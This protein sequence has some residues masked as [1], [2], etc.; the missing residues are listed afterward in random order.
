M[1]TSLLGI[2]SQD[3]HIFQDVSENKLRTSAKQ[4]NKTR[5]YNQLTQRQRTTIAG[6]K[7]AVK[8]LYIPMRRTASFFLISFF[9]PSIFSP[10]VLLYVLFTS[11][12]DRSAR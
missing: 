2:Y 10:D 9:S 4:P 7:A 3:S 8:L 6:V 11:S 5:I 1:K 12:L